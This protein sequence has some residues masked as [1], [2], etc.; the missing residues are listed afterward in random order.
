MCKSSFR[1]THLLLL[2]L[3][4]ILTLFFICGAAEGH[5]DFVIDTPSE[6][7]LPMPAGRSF[8]VSGSVKT[9]EPIPQ[10]AILKVE[11]LDAEGN[12][13]IECVASALMKALDQI[14]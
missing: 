10:G 4:C 3:C 5:C 9:E 2:S 11:L 1:K 13:E 7:N 14:G 8:Y 12:E 6:G